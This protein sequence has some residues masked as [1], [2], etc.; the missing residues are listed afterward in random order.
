M[1]TLIANIMH[2][3]RN[4]ETV[5]IGGGE[6]NADELRQIVDL[7]EAAKKAEE[8]PTASVQDLSRLEPFVQGL[9]K[10]ILRELMDAPPAQPGPDKYLQLALQAL[11]PLELLFTQA[12]NEGLLT[13]ANVHCQIDTNDLRKSAYVAS[14][15]RAHL[16][17]IQ[18]AQQAVPAIPEWLPIETAPKT[19]KA[20]LV[21]C[22]DRKNVYTASWGKVGGFLQADGWRHFGGG[23]MVETPT[24]WRP[25]PAAPAAQEPKKGQ[26]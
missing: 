13:D 24:H 12:D 2:A 18:S 22:A 5:T 21:Y 14:D 23:D 8:N 25:L 4:K 19:S 16:N 26:L 9:G 10:A 3:I 7:Y 1:K 20:I 6:F 15:I 11:A 17:T